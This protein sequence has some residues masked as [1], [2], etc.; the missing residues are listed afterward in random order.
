MIMVEMP[1]RLCQMLTQLAVCD[2]RCFQTCICTG[3]VKGYRVKADIRNPLRYSVK[4]SDEMKIRG[5]I[6][7]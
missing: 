5:G 2:R 4:K 7:K 1:S 3:L 6:I